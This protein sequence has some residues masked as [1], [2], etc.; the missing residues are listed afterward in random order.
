MLIGLT[1]AQ[2]EHHKENVPFSMLYYIPYIFNK[3][4]ACV[5]PRHNDRNDLTLGCSKMHFHPFTKIL[6]KFARKGT[7]GYI[8]IGLKI[9]GI[10]QKSHMF[11]GSPKGTDQ[12]TMALIKGWKCIL[13]HP[14]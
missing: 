8:T 2:A 6:V 14:T 9:F 13:K 12:K 10:L 5:S 1:V 3:F 4:E 7:V 11:I